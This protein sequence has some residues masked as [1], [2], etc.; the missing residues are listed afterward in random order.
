M[1]IVCD[2]QN[3]KIREVYNL[4][5]L[6]KHWKDVKEF[7]VQRLPSHI[8]LW[9][10]V[11]LEDF[12]PDGVLVARLRYGRVYICHWA[13]LDLCKEWLHRPVFRGAPLY[14]IDHWTEC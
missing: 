12:I 11:E 1:P 9:P 7:E 5:W 8:E 10:N 6:L 13:S 2:A 14:W 4:G 3:L